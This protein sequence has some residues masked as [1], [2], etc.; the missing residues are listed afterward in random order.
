M[1]PDRIRYSVRGVLRDSLRTVRTGGK[2]PGI[3]AYIVITD[4]TR[5]DGPYDDTPQNRIDR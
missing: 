2:I 1:M 4:H 5:W 3:Y